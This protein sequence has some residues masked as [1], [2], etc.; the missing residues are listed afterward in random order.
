[1]SEHTHATSSL[2][3]H[4]SVDIQVAIEF[5]LLMAATSE[6]PQ[7]GFLEPPW[8]FLVYSLP[9]LI[10]APLLVGRR[11]GGS[12]AHIVGCVW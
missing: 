2:P 8:K 12:I 6:W 3:G 9:S 4:V 5:Y 7:I 11:D 1:M 10:C